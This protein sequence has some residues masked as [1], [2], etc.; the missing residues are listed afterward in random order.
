MSD[1]NKKKKKK[2]TSQGDRIKSIQKTI[3]LFQ[4][5]SLRRQFWG[6]AKA[7]AEMNGVNNE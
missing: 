1:K 5:T 3:L 7:K 6:V 2:K 4:N